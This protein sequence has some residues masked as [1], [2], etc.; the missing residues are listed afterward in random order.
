MKL[1][2]R[3]QFSHRYIKA[4]V[5]GGLLLA[6]GL[7]FNMTN[8]NTVPSWALIVGFVLVST[9]V[10][11]LFTG[12]CQLGSFYG[13]WSGV[14]AK[15]IAR[16]LGISSGIAIALQSLGELS[17]R[18]VVV[19]LLLTAIAFVYISYGREQHSHEQHK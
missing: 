12:I 13:L 2:T 7:F 18:D 16:L 15:R 1:F 11:S 5:M 4:L 6:D 10:Y 3:P 19:L 8:P 9:T 14:N 17:L